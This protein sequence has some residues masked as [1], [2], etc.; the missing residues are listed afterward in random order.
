MTG[1]LRFVEMT[2]AGLAHEMK[3]RKR[4]LEMTEKFVTSYLYSFWEYE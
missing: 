4:P 3:K 2:G 1:R